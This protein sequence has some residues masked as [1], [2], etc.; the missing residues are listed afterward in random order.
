MT[1]ANTPDKTDQNTAQ[2]VPAYEV[3]EVACGHP[4]KGKPPR[5][6][7]KMRKAIR[8]HVRE[9]NKIIDACRAAG[10]AEQTW[11]RNMKRPHVLQCFEFEKSL[12]I[13]E[14]EELKSRHKARALEV[15]VEL[16]EGAA[17]EA[18]KARMVEFLAGESKSQPSVT[19]NNSIS[20]GGYEYAP[21]G[22]RVVEIE[23]S[24]EDVTPDNEST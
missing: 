20:T 8:L 24:A 10:I 23:G 5:V 22:A 2:P 12:Y 9:G 13:Q 14:V 15:A 16:M 21:K 6:S 18:V 17:S 4:R 19:I 3:A 11:Y 7:A 1:R